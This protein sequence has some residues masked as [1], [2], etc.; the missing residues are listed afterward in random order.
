MHLLL[1]KISKVLLSVFG[2]LKSIPDDDP[3]LTPE[4]WCMEQPCMKIR[5]ASKEM[6]IS[7]PLSSFW[8]YFLGFFTV[9]NQMRR[10]AGL[11]LDQ[12]VG[13]RLPHVPAG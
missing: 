2:R 10:E 8:V 4:N 1:T 9:G 5:I 11:Q 12:L 3:D 13:G 7:Q 6:I